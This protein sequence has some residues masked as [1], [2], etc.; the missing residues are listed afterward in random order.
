VNIFG[1]KTKE[2]SLEILGIELGEERTKFVSYTTGGAWSFPIYDEIK[3][4]RPAVIYLNI[5]GEEYKIGASIPEQIRQEEI[6]KLRGLI[7]REITVDV[8]EPYDHRTLRTLVK[9]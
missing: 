3:V 8:K 4:R 7:G 6:E 9:R 5:D 2:R 1:R